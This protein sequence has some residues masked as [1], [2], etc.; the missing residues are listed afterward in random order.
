MLIFYQYMVTICS[1]VYRIRPQPQ[2]ASRRPPARILPRRRQSQK[3]DPRQSLQ[4]APRSG[5][6]LA[7]PAQGRHRPERASRRPSTSCAPA[8]TATSPPCSARLRK[9]RLERLIAPATL[10]R[11]RPGAGDD[12]RPGARPGLQAGHRAQPGRGPP[13]AIRWPRRLPSGPWT[14]TNCTPPWTGC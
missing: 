13:P 2:L 10:A 12:R 5:R 8:P 14:R 4:M 7:R 1:H 3:T 6:G 11:S 9:L